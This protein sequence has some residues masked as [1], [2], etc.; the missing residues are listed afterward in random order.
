MVGQPARRPRP[1]L[2]PRFVRHRAPAVA[3]DA[4]EQAAATAGMLPGFMQ[5]AAMVIGNGQYL[6]T[7]QRRPVLGLDRPV[8]ML[9]QVSTLSQCTPPRR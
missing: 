6:A 8:P 5:S 7:G 4:L 3:R 1:L 2:D 9:V